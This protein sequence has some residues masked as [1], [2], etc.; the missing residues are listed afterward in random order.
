MLFWKIS[1][2]DVERNCQLESVQR[3]GMNVQIRMKDKDVIAEL[4]VENREIKRRI[5]YHL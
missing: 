3:N 5:P 4:R 1:F 2:L